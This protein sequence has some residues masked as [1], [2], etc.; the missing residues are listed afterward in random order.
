MI[1]NNFYPP[2]T[3]RDAQRKILPSK[4][5]YIDFENKRLSGKVDGIDALKQSIYMILQ[6]ER[7]RWLIYSRDY[8]AEFDELRNNPKTYIIPQLQRR[9]T[10]A[11]MVDDRITAVSGFKFETNKN[12]YSVTFEVTSNIADDKITQTYDVEV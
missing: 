5:F 11:L 2:E 7:Y 1:P 8:G 4:T 9:I 10:E 12:I 6:T 3:F